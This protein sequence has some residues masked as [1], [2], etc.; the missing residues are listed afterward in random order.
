MPMFLYFRKMWE[1]I[2]EYQQLH[3]FSRHKTT[4]IAVISQL[5]YEDAMALQ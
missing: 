1:Q 3:I 5:R 4:F 2:Q